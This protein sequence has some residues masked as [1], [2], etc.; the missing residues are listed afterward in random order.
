MFYKKTQT[1]QK[2]NKRQLGETIMFKLLSTF[3]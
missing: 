3:V 2:K 1:N